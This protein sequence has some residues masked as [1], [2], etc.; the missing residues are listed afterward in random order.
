MPAS[1][2]TAVGESKLYM[3]NLFYNTEV[4]MQ[5]FLYKFTFKL[6]N[7]RT[8]LYKLLLSLNPF[9]ANA[10]KLEAQIK[11]FVISVKYLKLKIAKHR[12]PSM[13]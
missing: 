7:T 11:A 2:A 4:S 13:H 10:R 8:H 1:P 9:L 5:S 3:A 12:L 6:P